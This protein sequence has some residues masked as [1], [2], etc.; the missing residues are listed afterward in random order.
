MTNEVLHPTSF[1]VPKVGSAARVTMIPELGTLVYNTDT[2]KMATNISEML[3][4][5][6]IIKL[7]EVS[8]LWDRIG[9]FIYNHRLYTFSGG[10]RSI[11]SSIQTRKIDNYIYINLIEEI[12]INIPFRYFGTSHIYHYDV[13]FWIANLDITEETTILYELREKFQ[14][15]FESPMNLIKMDNLR[16]KQLFKDQFRKF[17]NIIE[18][19]K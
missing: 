4:I 14:T 5:N 19:E 10:E 3:F 12:K 13:D 6:D 18:I 9:T 2:N 15:F 11:I 8:L 16:W 7:K 1:I 17:D